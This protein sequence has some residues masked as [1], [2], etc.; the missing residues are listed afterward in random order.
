[1]IR[2]TW[3]AQTPDEFD[4]LDP[5]SLDDARLVD[6][7]A[8]AAGL[9]DD[10][11]ITRFA[12]ELVRRGSPAAQSIDL[13]PLVSALVREAMSRGTEDDALDWIERA[14]PLADAETALAIDVWRAEI[15]ARHD[16]GDAALEVY[17]SLIGSGGAG[18]AMALDGALTL[19]DNGHFDLAVRLLTQARDLAHDAGDCTGSSSEQRGFSPIRAAELARRHSAKKQ[20][21]GRV[22]GLVDVRI[23]E[24]IEE[25]LE[26]GFLVGRNL[27]ADQG[28]DRN[29]PLDFDSGTG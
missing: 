6:A 4:E 13:R 22:L 28:C 16:R 12:A 20:L 14:R 3:A 17:Q 8:S 9:G 25:F 27:D 23:S 19:I 10:R 1:M 24:R 29:R 18:A 15:L 21:I 5:H 7:A 11:R 26:G 2:L